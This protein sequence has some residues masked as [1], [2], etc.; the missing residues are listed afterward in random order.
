MYRRLLVATVA[1]AALV[2]LALPTGS[3][4]AAPAPASPSAARFEGRTIDLSKNWEEARSCLVWRAQNAVECFRTPQERDSRAQRLMA[5]QNEQVAARSCR[6]PLHLYEHVRGRGRDLK[7]YDR[8]YWQNLDRYNFNDK[9]SSYRTG[10]CTA[11]LAE[12]NNGRGYWYPGNTRPRH[13]EP[14]M[15]RGWNDRVSSIKLD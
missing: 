2:T 13:Y 5:R 1:S 9:T 12:H 3:A 6:T 10:S 7:F 8:G 4:G 11:H 15:R 14:A